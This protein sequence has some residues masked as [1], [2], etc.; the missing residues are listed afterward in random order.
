MSVCEN[1]KFRCYTPAKTNAP[2][3]DCYPAEEWCEEDSDNF[4]TD[5]G[6]YKYENG[7]WDYD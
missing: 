7:E 1:C 6:C 3:E 2:P 4:M 5:D